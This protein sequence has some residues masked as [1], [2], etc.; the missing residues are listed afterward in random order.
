MVFSNDTYFI[1]IFSAEIKHVKI[2][3]IKYPI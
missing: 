3:V 1:Y 2:I